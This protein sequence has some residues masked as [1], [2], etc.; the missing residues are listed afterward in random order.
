MDSD[1]HLAREVEKSGTYGFDAFRSRTA[2]PIGRVNPDN[3]VTLLTKPVCGKPQIHLSGSLPRVDIVVSFSGA[4]GLAIDASVDAGA[5]AIVH[6]GLSPGIATP[7]EAEAIARAADRGVIV[8]Q[9]S[10]G[11]A[12]PVLK[13]YQMERVASIAAR[14]LSPKK[15]RLLVMML[16]AS[17]MSKSEIEE[18]WANF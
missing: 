18:N 11:S 17:G 2:G 6:C 3:T 5:A 1:I 13:T 7:R 8:I 12:G 16:V 4:D 9:G 14:D 10:Y 15:S